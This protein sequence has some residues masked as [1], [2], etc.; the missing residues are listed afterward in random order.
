[1]AGPTTE[2]GGAEVKKF[3]SW[4]ATKHHERAQTMKQTRLLREEKAAAAKEKQTKGKGKGSSAQD[5]PSHD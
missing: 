4:L 3:R 2:V 1:M 5:G